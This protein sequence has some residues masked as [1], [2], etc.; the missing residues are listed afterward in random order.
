MFQEC[1]HTKNN[2]NYRSIDFTELLKGAHFLVFF[3]P[4]D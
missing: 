2:V 4:G 1:V 3:P